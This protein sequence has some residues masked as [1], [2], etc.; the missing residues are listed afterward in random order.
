MLKIILNILASTPLISQSIS[1]ENPLKWSTLNPGDHVSVIAPGYGGHDGLI[2]K[3][4]EN[5]STFG[6]VAR[7]PE[8][9]ID[10]QPLG[11]SNTIEYRTDHLLQEL[12]AEGTK[13][14][15]A[16]RGGRGSSEILQYLPEVEYLKTPPLIVGF[17]DATALHLLATANNWPSLHG[18]VLGYNKEAGD[19]INAE[20]SLQ[21]YFDILTGNVTE[22][23][24]T[25]TPLNS[26]ATQE[27]YSLE[28]PVV[29]GNVSLIQ[30]SIGTNT[31]L[32][33][34]GKVLFLEDTGE[35]ATRLKETLVHLDRTGAFKSPKAVIWGNFDHSESEDRKYQFLREEFA[36]RLNARGIPFIHS[37]DF[38]HGK[39]NNPLPFNTS[40]TLSFNGGDEVLMKVKT[41]N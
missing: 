6:F 3:A 36:E 5:I 16:L 41:N 24:Y 26:A 2:E 19:A 32:N 1:T 29:G 39:K 35:Q 15:W 9:L 7:F 11:Y 20:T 25:F 30:R 21:D 37:P 31:H 28:A 10:P 8:S 33:T 38:G 18:V 22:L 14:I 4:K 17:S 27:D 40:A 12:T 34:A 13:V 23:E